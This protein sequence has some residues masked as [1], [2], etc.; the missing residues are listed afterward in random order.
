MEVAPKRCALRAKDSK[1]SGDHEKSCRI[2]ELESRGH[3]DRI[4]VDPNNLD[5]RQ[6]RSWHDI[7]I[8][9]RTIFQKVEVTPA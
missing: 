3:I 5:V 9:K 4:R 1:I 8:S 6:Q 7:S 2:G